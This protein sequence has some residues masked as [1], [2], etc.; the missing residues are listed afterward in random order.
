MTWKIFSFWPLSNQVKQLTTQAIILKGDFGLSYAVDIMS[1]WQRAGVSCSTASEHKCS[2]H[3]WR[4]FFS[5]WLCLLDG[6][7]SVLTGNNAIQKFKGRW[8][9]WASAQAADYSSNS[10][11]NYESKNITLPQVKT[12]LNNDRKIPWVHSYRRSYQVKR[13]HSQSN[14]YWLFSLEI[15]KGW[16][17]SWNIK[18]FKTLRWISSKT[19]SREMTR[20]EQRLLE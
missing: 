17:E 3:K 18:L 5:V 1:L 9:S 13:E 2:W 6:C 4:K 12:T 15:I 20:N 7:Y 8:G 11:S 14:L 16:K 19:D 10:N